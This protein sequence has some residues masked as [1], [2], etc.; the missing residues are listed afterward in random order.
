MKAER[1]MCRMVEG[2]RAQLSEE[3]KGQCTQSTVREARGNT[4]SLETRSVSCLNISS[5]KEG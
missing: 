3:L 5:G 1:S 2:P 4:M